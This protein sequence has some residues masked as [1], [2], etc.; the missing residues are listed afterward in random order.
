MNPG[1]NES[2]DVRM[3]T[4]EGLKTASRQRAHECVVFDV[5]AQVNVNVNAAT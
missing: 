4:T 2:M 3:K 1:M 5:E